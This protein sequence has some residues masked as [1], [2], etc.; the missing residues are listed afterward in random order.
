MERPVPKWNQLRLYDQASLMRKGYTQI[1]FDK[2]NSEYRLTVLTLYVKLN[3]IK[4]RVKR[5]NS[6]LVNNR[7]FW[8]DHVFWWHWTDAGCL[9]FHVY[10]VKELKRQLTDSPDFSSPAASDDSWNSIEL[11]YKGALHLKHEANWHPQKRIIQAHID[12]V[13][14]RG[15]TLITLP[16]SLVHHG[17][18]YSS[19]G[20]PYIA[21][22]ILLSQGWD[23][24]PLLGVG[25]RY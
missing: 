19:Y 2:M 4:L 25:V 11:R 14:W 21:R 24:V 16:I 12:E 18:T 10:D 9:T 6:Y 3:G 20:K 15:A 5:S 1:W 13:G 23:P 22:E 7:S 17:I 8:E